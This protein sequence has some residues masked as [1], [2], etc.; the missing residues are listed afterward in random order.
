MVSPDFPKVLVLHE[1]RYLDFAFYV[2][3]NKIIKYGV[4][5]IPSMGFYFRINFGQWGHPLKGPLS[6]NKLSRSRK[7][8]SFPYKDQRN[9]L[10]PCL[11]LSASFCTLYFFGRMSVISPLHQSPIRI[12]AI[13]IKHLWFIQAP[14]RLLAEPENLRYHTVSNR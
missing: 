12:K 13:C 5:G 9:Y 6:K 4:P 3:G 1:Y 14:F 7:N 10:P 8:G 2:Q 11:R